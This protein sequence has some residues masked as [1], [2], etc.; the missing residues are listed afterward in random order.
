MMILINA[1]GAGIVCSMCSIRF[2]GRGSNVLVA[3]FIGFMS[4]LVMG[5]FSGMYVRAFVSG[6]TYS[7]LSE[8]FSRI[9]DKPVS[10]YLPAVLVPFVPG[11]LTYYMMGE[12]VHGDRVAAMDRVSE[13]L[14][15]CGMIAL[16]ILLTETA[17]RVWTEW[18][19]KGKQKQASL[20]E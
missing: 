6:L 17:I 12:F 9:F 19:E 4:A 13:I 18:H 2:N 10:V 3:G 5:F 20:N 14:C 16:A 7:I 8:I 11:K 15:V 1:I